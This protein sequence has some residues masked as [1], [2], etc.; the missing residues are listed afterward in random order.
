MNISFS[1]LLPSTFK[2]ENMLPAFWM[3][4]QGLVVNDWDAVYKVPE[5]CKVDVPALYTVY[6]EDAIT[7]PWM[8]HHTLY[9]TSH[10]QCGDDPYRQL[11][12]RDDHHQVIQSTIRL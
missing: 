11:S 7:K 3:I 9:Y 10:Q 6:K 5:V 12:D 4:F 2:E 1:L 8:V